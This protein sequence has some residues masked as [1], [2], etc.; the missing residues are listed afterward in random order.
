MAST[1]SW[2][3]KRREQE[4]L[5]L[6]LKHLGHILEVAE[7][8]IGMVE[9]L[10]IGD[11]TRIEEAYKR[12]KEAERRADKVKDD[13]IADLSGGLFHPIDREE[14]LRLV[15]VSDDIADHLNAGSR[16]LLVYARASMDKAP[17]EYLEAVKDITVKA[18]DSIKLIIDAVKNL[19]KDPKKSIEL[20]RM[21]E[22][23]EEEVDEIRS[24]TEEF[25]VSWCNEKG[26][27][28]ECITLH[29]SLES[30]ETST[31]KCE[32]TADVIRSIAILSW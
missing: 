26:R 27:P 21:V 11:K 18:R 32:D 13:I 17:E 1:W 22:R 31:D 2:I 14:L 16:R 29:S 19:R 30:Y 7:N 9:A 23:I 20:A 25:L 24:R 12:V 10:K 28:G 5:E 8:S 4:I 15:I 3:G 6:E